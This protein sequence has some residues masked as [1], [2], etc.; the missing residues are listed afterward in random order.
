M[1]I[2]SIPAFMGQIELKV[3]ENERGNLYQVAQN[4]G[5]VDFLGLYS[6][7]QLFF[8]TL[9][10]RTSFPHYTNTKMIKFG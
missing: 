3:F 10:D 4:N 8:F 9:L 6:D 1:D 7:Q 2:F 5:T